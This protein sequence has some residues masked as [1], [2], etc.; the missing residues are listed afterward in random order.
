[1]MKN[2]FVLLTLAA[3]SAACSSAGDEPPANAVP[4]CSITAPDDGAVLDP[5]ADLVITGTG[6]DT[7]GSIVKVT[8]TVAG[9]TVTEATSVP[10]SH[11]VPADELNEGELTITLSVED[12]RGATAFDEVTVTLQ[13]NSQ[14]PV[15]RITSPVD[16]A[17]V[18]LHEPLVVSGEGGT[19]TGAIDGVTLTVGGTEVGEVDALPFS[20][21][22]SPEMLSDGEL[23]IILTV[24]NDA[25]KVARDKVTV[26]V[27]DLNEAPVCKIVSP[28]DGSETEAG[29]PLVIAGT[30]SDNDGSIASVVLT[31]NETVMEAVTA[32]PFEYELPADM[33]REGEMVILLTVEDDFGKTASDKVAVNILGRDRTFTDPRDAK[34]Y[35]TVKLG[36]QEWFAEN[37]AYLPEVYPGNVGSND[38]GYE[39][40]LMYYVYGYFGTDVAEAKASDTYKTA[41]VLYNW[42]AAAGGTVGSDPSAVPSGVQGPCPDG[43]HVPSRAEW[44]ILNEW[45]YAQIP[46]EDGVMYSDDGGSPSGDSGM[47]LCKNV[48]GAL[49][50][51]DVWKADYSEDELPQLALGGIDL[52]GFRGLPSG[53]RLHTGDYFY[54]YTNNQQLTFWT[55]DWNTYF[56]SNPGGGTIAFT[57]LYYDLRFSKGGSATERGYSIRCV[58]D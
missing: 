23:E 35:K 46:D 44:V 17:V 41:G 48:N 33:V 2:Y 5:N 56:P 7:D 18:G 26:T 24:S 37:L 42:Y 43:W 38:D 53:C 10:F 15:C 39:N 6:E 58:R 1:M 28:A 45:A 54:Y 12:D 3:F 50:A 49:K 20:Y 22:V 55:P 47:R 57:S 32:V 27:K 34:T 8:L 13:D 31:V 19:E 9:R 4:V 52:F 51:K 16:G 21:T 30:G 40:K 14:A 11:T 36:G 29:V 25:G